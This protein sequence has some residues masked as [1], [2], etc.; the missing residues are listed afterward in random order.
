VGR[1]GLADVD[2][3]YL[4]ANRAFVAC[5]PRGEY[6]ERRDVAIVCCG[7]PAEQLNWGLLK[8]PCR[9]PA[10]TAEAVRVYF[11]ERALPFQVSAREDDGKRPL[12]GLEAIGWRRRPDA[13]PGMTLAI[14]ASVPKPPAPL[15]IDRVRS[16]EELVAFRETAFVGFG[17]PAA[18]AG[19]FLNERLLALPG[20]RLYSGRLDG[21][22][23]ATSMLMATGSVAGIYW[24][25][26]LEAQRGRGYG[27]ALT[28]AAVA[29]GRELGCAVASLQASKQGRPVY[30]RMGFEHVLDYAHYLP[31]EV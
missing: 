7:L 29:G 17:F 21:A 4:D 27:E 9:D 10:A 11:G 19:L 15:V 14:P 8:P 25:A 2:W 20:V 26:T 23:V 16:A 24:V 13:T 31:P 1:D 3:N 12:Q 28:W 22:V 18:T 6:L 30:A 5:S